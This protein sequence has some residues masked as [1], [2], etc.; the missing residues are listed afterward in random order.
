M[1]DLAR[2]RN[3]RRAG[4]L[5]VA[6]LW[7]P[8]A[9]A[10][11]GTAQ[12]AQATRARAEP[13][14]PTRVRTESPHDI[15]YAQDFDEL[16]ETLGRRYCFFADK[17]IDWNAVRRHYRPLAL[18]A[19]D[20]EA[21]ERV[22]GD[23][24]RELYDAHT[25]LAAPSDGTPRWPPFDLLASHD[26]DSLRI[27]AVQPGSAAADAGLAIG[28]RVLAIEGMAAASVVR[29]LVPRCLTRRDAKAE[30]Y[31][32]NAAV[33]GRRGQPR[34]FDVRRGAAPPREVQIALKRHDAP[35][36]ES[37]VL[38][39]GLGYIALRSFADD[40][41]VAAFDAALAE[42]R[43]AQGLVIDVR[44][45]GGGD[46]AVARPI[47]GRFIH[48]TA[49]YARMR[50][51]EGAGLGPYWT[52]VVEP[53]GPFTFDAPVV[54]LVDHWSGSMAEGFPMGMHG[55]GRAIIVGTPMMGLGAAVFTLRLD[56]TGIAAQYSAE[57]VYDRHGHPRWALR[58][59][60]VVA[61]GADIL[62]AGIA[63]LRLRAP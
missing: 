27:V 60:I 21:F 55:L 14:G 13:L 52:E 15:R 7:V 38:E 33:A 2:R 31:A 43:G 16:W 22:L 30:A 63:A 20:D 49:P 37:R 59:D 56:R 32:V 44:G 5:L 12:G 11:S 39:D 48:A 34:R 57:P 61:E 51:R 50:R 36:V 18:R 23:V 24:L 54:V 58:P 17:A 8:Q 40:K 45:N 47:M 6:P 26:G 35:D 1:A 25:H 53:R 3:L 4:A 42:L 41:V 46:T 28:D 10:A 62:A 9:F 19:P 29:D